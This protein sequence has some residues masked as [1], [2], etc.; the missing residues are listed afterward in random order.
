MKKLIFCLL[1]LMALGATAFFTRPTLAEHKVAIRESASEFVGVAN[2]EA[3][4]YLEKA[5]ECVEERDYL[6]CTVCVLPTSTSDQMLSLGIFGK[7]FTIRKNK[8]TE[9]FVHLQ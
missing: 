5:L 7:V 9:N 3:Q 1:L 2:I 8:I 4:L 6:V